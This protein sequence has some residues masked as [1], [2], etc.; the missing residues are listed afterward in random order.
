MKKYGVGTPEYNPCG[1]SLFWDNTSI[2]EGNT[3]INKIYTNSSEMQ[4]C[5]S[6]LV[7]AYPN[8]THLNEIQTSP[9]VITYTYNGVQRTITAPALTQIIL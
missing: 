7:P 2:S 5:F 3:V 8:S 9:A 4:F 1:T 6:F